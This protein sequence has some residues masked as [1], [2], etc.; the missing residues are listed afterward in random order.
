MVWL[1]RKLLATRSTKRSG[2]PLASIC[3]ILMRRKPRQRQSAR[4]QMLT[5]IVHDIRKRQA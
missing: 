1:F 5:V 3:T 4:A 2:D